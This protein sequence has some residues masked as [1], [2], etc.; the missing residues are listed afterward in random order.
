[1]QSVGLPPSSASAHSKFLS[2]QPHMAGTPAQA[3]TRDYVIEQDEIV[4]TRDE[5][6]AYSVWMPHP[7]STRVWRIS[8]DPIELDLQE[9]PVA[10]DTTSFA[11]PQVIAI[12]RIQRR[13]RCAR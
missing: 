13:G 2:L 5:V 8:P 11:F 7:L 10:E 3:R 6:R 4:G 9:G 1:M 12:Q